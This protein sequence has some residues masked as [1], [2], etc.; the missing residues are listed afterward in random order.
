MTKTPEKPLYLRKPAPLACLEHLDIR[1]SNLFRISTFDI[2]ICARIKT[3]VTTELFN[4]HQQG[5]WL[6]DDLE[7]S[8]SPSRL[9][10]TERLFGKIVACGLI[11][12]GTTSPA[13]LPILAS[14]A[15]TFQVV[16]VSEGFEYF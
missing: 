3:Q 5:R 12:P 10:Q 8:S 14:A 7:A 1:I 15:F 4:P 6:I 11:G 9:V 2:R 16:V 13:D